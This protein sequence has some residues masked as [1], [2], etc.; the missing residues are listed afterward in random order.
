MKILSKEKLESIKTSDI[1]N[2]LSKYRFEYKYYITKQ[3]KILLKI[4]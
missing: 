2:T 3:D 1:I 4:E